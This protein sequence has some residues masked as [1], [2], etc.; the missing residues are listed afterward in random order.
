MRAASVAC[1]GDAAGPLDNGGGVVGVG[2]TWTPAVPLL[3]AGA[4]SGSVAKPMLC[5]PLLRN[6]ASRPTAAAASATTAEPPRYST[7]RRARFAGPASGSAAFTYS[8]SRNSHPTATPQPIYTSTSHTTL[9]SGPAAGKP[10]VTSTSSVTRNRIAA[11]VTATVAV[12]WRV[13]RLAA[14][15]T[16]AP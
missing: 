7:S 8:T 5:V 15:A 9:A 2:P 13:A 3:G 11:P 14:R 6:A 4:A 10:I 12:R 1:G 16:P